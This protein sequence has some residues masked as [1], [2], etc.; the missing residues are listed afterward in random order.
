MKGSRGSYRWSGSAEGK[1]FP[2]RIWFVEGRQEMQGKGEA[3]EVIRKI[4]QEIAQRY[5]PE[6]MILFGSYAYGTPTGES[7]LDFLV[8]MSNPPS[9]S[10]LNA[11]L[12][13]ITEGLDM[14]VD[15][16]AMAPEE[17]EETKDVIGGLAYA[18]AKYG[19]VVY[20]KP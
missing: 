12:L 16:F 3:S 14:P 20:E 13:E 18:P 17:F 2:D 11:G 19:K 6:K 15:F 10:E 8:I 4:V 5:S 7:D 9:H 1:L